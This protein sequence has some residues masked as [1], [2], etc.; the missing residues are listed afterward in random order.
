MEKLL[1]ELSQE[2]Q[3]GY[4]LPELDIPVKKLSEIIPEKYFRTDT[5]NLPQISEPEIRR[6]YTRLSHLNYSLTTNFYPLGSCTM[7]YNPVINEQ[8]SSFSGFANLH[9][10]QPEKTVQGILEIL[11]EL[12]EQMCKIT[13]MD[14]FTLQPAAGA[15]GEFTGLLIANAYF[16]SKNEKRTKIIVPDSA[17]GTNPASASLAGFEIIPFRS[18]PDG[19]IDPEKL[20]NVLTSE[21]AVIMLTVP[22]TLGVF[23]K[24]IIEIAELAHKNGTLLYYDGANLNALMGIARPGDFGFDI[25]HVNLHKTFSTPHGGGGPGSGPIGVKNKLAEFLP[26][27]TIEKNGSDYTFNFGL[28]RS[29]GRVKSYY[30]N[31]P[32]LI[33]AYSY[34]CALGKEG[35]KKAS[36][37][38]VINANY[39]LHIL[40]G[41]LNAPAG[42]KCMHEFV[43]SGK[44]CNEYGVKTVDIAKRLLDYG[45]YAPTV[46][47]PLIVEEAIM[48][49]PTE[50]ETKET[51]DIFAKIFIQIVEEAKIDPNKLKNAPHKTPVSRLNEVEAARKPRFHW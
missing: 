43:L 18:E 47:F 50:T 35:L 12:N 42:D 31:I 10:Y 39:L 15:H 48:V 3:Q 19:S 7:K 6:H 29:I 37:Q 2:G 25:I 1:N 40:K 21:V 8:I 9:P 41:K 16:K 32:V 49:E 22:N 26:V 24:N 33:K 27:P 14:K 5:V 38:A 46:Y 28:H 4:S 20:K 13:G 34:I 30:G 23:E 11:F 51:L 17:H 44:S 36:E 45:Y